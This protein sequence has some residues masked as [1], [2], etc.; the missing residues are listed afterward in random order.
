[1]SLRYRVWLRVCARSQADRLLNLAR[2]GGIPTGRALMTGER[3]Y[4]GSGK[5]YEL[6]FYHVP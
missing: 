4:K 6:K 2:K 1:M 3:V 5:V